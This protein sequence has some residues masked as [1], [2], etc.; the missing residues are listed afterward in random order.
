M[1]RIFVSHASSDGELADEVHR[2]LATYKHQVFLARNIREGIP[3]GDLWKERLHQELRAADA[4]VCVVTE[5][6]N[7]SPWCAYEIGIAHEVGSMLVPLRAQPGVSSPLLEDRQYASADENAQWAGDLDA[8]LRREDKNGGRATWNR[9]PFP[10][11]QPFR[12]DMARVFFGRDDELRRLAHRLRALSDRRLLLV[13]GGSGCGKSSLV[14]AGLTARFTE[15]PGWLVAEPFVPGRDPIRKLALTLANVADSVGLP[16]TVAGLDQRLREDPGALLSITEELLEAGP[17]PARLRL[18]VVVDQGEELFT[19]TPPEERTRFAAVLAAGLAGPLRVV[20]AVRSEFQDQWFAIPELQSANLHAFPLR[21]LSREML[22]V[23]ITEPARVAGLRVDP[24]LV[25]RMVE[26]TEGGEALPLLAFTLDELAQGLSRGDRL[27]RQRYEDLGG[28]RGALA[29]RADAVLEEAVTEARLSRE[30]I[31]AS[32][33]ELATIDEVGRRT[34]RRVDFDELSTDA[35]RLAF[36]VFVEQRLLS[37]PGEGLG[38]RAVGV[39]HEALLTE[40]A[41]LDSVIREREAVLFTEGQ[42]ER[43]AAAWGRGGPLWDADQLAAAIRVLWGSRDRFRKGHR[44]LVNLN[45]AGRHFLDACGQRADTIARRARLRRRGV[46]VLLSTLLVAALVLGVI[47]RSAQHDADQA[48]IATL[49][50]SLLA[51]AGDTRGTDRIKA[52]RLGLAAAT[53]DPGQAS[54]DSLLQDLA[55]EPTGVL[56]I[57]APVGALALARRADGSLLLAAG[58]ADARAQLWKIARSGETSTLG[59]P[60]TGLHGPVSSVTL[61]DDAKTLTASDTANNHLTWDLTVPERPRLEPDRPGSTPVG[62][63]DAAA[64]EAGSP[65]LVRSRDGRFQVVARGQ[66]GPALRG[67][68]SP[69]PAAGELTVTTCCGQPPVVYAHASTDTGAVRALAISPDG[70]ILASVD[71][72]RGV[73][74]WATDPASLGHRRGPGSSSAPWPALTALGMPLAGHT[75]SPLSLAF[76]PDGTILASGA[77]DGTIRLWNLTAAEKFTEGTIVSYACVV[78]GGGLDGS[79]WRYYLPGVRFRDICSP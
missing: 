6:Y 46:V 69:G 22:S 3:P 35:L 71:A 10:G 2:A 27:S 12:R 58:E 67:D 78:A 70:N 42:V 4:V 14:S 33:A 29:R 30:E 43:A 31:L 18:L 15:E 40:W 11:L 16:W 68:G 17:G 72:G 23:V 57:G 47:A 45:Q 26:D 64:S 28:V 52:L 74:L 55:T 34:R 53:I 20:V 7:A 49:A 66:A 13:V 73:R 56:N 5:A 75:L 50:R 38:A 51:A 9:S 36:G 60:L 76:S 37:T 48:R 61:T 32:M 25:A 24:E 21:P 79:S 65:L 1:A 59:A 8:V 41:P 19:R 77:N 44:P 63:P 39:V 62:T 54:E